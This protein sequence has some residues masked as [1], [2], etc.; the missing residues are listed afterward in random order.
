MRVF[1][2]FAF[3]L[4]VFFI[5]LNTYA[6]TTSGNPP[7]GFIFVEGGTF[8][9]GSDLGED[10]EKPVHKV[11]VNSFYV[12][13]FEVTQAE[14]K[15]LM[16][17]LPCKERGDMYP[18]SHLTTFTDALIYCNK[19][20]L[21]EGRTPCYSIEG[22]TDIENSGVFDDPVQCDFSANGYRLL[23]EAEWEYAARGG[24]LSKGFLYSG[25]NN[26][27][28]V[29]WYK[30]NS[31]EEIVHQVGTKA[32][33]EL[34]L[35]DMSGNVDEWCWDKYDDEFYEASPEL[36]PSNRDSGTQEVY[37]GGCYYYGAGNCAVYKRNFDEGVE[38]IA[39]VGLR[40]AV[41]K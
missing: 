12:S 26:V 20:S 36:N 31:P 7:N 4:F 39:I 16:G 27:E 18:V 23:T 2:F 13:K 30:E 25:S 17:E 19:R 37:R 38:Y 3:T 32:P 40:L 35:F 9:M 28:E 8:M 24:K 6:Q 29:A 33:N 22:K 1:S 14:W 5:P 21:K 10:D 34:G 11:T 15:E 41:S